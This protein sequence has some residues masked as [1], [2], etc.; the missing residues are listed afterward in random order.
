M[1]AGEGQEEAGAPPLPGSPDREHCCGRALHHCQGPDPRAQTQ[2]VGLFLGVVT[3]GSPR[4]G[5]PGGGQR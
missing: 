2:Q 4:A 5:E 1:S 3:T